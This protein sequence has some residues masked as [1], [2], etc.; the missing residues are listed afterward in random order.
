VGGARAQHR[1]RVLTR[2]S[3]PQNGETPLHIAAGRGH[4]PVVRVLVDAGADKNAPR[5]VIEG[6]GGDVGHTQ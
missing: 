2:G 1:V 3:V 5:K 6:R 4:L